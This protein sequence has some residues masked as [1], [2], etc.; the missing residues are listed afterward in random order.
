MKTVIVAAYNPEDRTIENHGKILKYFTEDDRGFRN[1]RENHPV[2]MGGKTFRTLLRGHG[3]PVP[4]RTNIVVSPR[5]KEW[6]K[7]VEG[8]PRLTS[9]ASADYFAR[10]YNMAP[11][12]VV[13]R[14]TI[15]TALEYAE[16][17]SDKV[18]IA[19]GTSR[20][21]ET[22]SLADRLEITEVPNLAPGDKKF[23]VIS[24]IEWQE[25][26]RELKNGHSFVTYNRIAN[27]LK[28]K[29]SW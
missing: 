1:S 28:D 7:P 29:P 25:I 24:P 15:E 8:L 23:P 14:T 10:V 5:L 16:T 9:D 20:Y 19:G 11:F 17:I 6:F 12:G 4:E 2:I 18:F 13:V 22:M 27:L 21:G 3:G 26:Y